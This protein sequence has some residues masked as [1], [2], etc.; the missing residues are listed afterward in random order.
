MVEH[1]AL[2]LPAKRRGLIMG[3]APAVAP[4]PGEI[5]IRAHAV[6]VNP[7]DRYIQTM[8]DVITS[9]LTYPAVPGT[10]V[11]GEVLAIGAGV[12]RFAPGDRVVG[13]AAGLEKSRNRAAEGAFQ[14]K[15]LLLAHMTAPIPAHLSYEQAA[16]L[17]LG[18]STAA[19]G[20]YQKDFLGLAAPQ[21]NP[22]PTGETLLV[23]GGST[24]VGS[25]AI[26]LARASG[27]EVITTCS[28]HNFG[29]VR[30]LGASEAFD[31]NSPDVKRTIIGALRG[32]KMAG[33]IAIG[34]G[35][36]K[37]CMDILAQSTGRRFVAQAT[38]PTSFDSVPAGKG[39]WRKLVPSV[40]RMIMG[41]LALTLRSYR[42]GAAT[43]MIWAG[44]LIH[45]DV[46]PMI[47][48]T[49]LPKA[50][51]Q[52][53]YKAMP[54]AH[55]VGHGLGHVPEAMEQQRCGVSARKLVVTL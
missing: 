8:G 31:Y 11:A 38:P 45:N 39:R 46:G 47:Y 28:P 54:P 33:A 34:K 41:N 32:R 48:E 43:R 40:A 17:P 7:F 4:G 49:Y 6:A 12:T 27:Y 53:A 37:A 25:N 18:L 23:W 21:I 3:P 5:V 13:Q 30:S 19:C 44:S 2:W 9:Y 55:V 50:L 20:M 16:V 35:S 10:D 14:E 36:A 42:L 52:D 15:V 26:Q 22:V 1:A 24:S 51:A 29:Y